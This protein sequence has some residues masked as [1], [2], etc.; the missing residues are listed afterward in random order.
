MTSRS[1]GN[2][3]IILILHLICLSVRAGGHGKG[4]QNELTTFHFLHRWT[5]ALHVAVVSQA[6][7][8]YEKIEKGSGQKPLCI[9]LCNDYTSGVGF[10]YMSR[11][12]F[13][14]IA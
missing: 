8:P 6:S 1:Q 4:I 7:P 3:I 14:Y 5:L 9:W 11:Q 13:I 12:T 2:P 10:L